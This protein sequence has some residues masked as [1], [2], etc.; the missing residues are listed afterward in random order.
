MPSRNLGNRMRR[1]KEN[2][3]AMAPEFE[4]LTKNLTG[5]VDGEGGGSG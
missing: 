3:L 4:R 5:R 2:G 1:R